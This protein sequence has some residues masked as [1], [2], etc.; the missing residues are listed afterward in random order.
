M[1]TEIALFSTIVMKS[2]FILL[3]FLV[4]KSSDQ[5]LATQ[6]TEQ[7]STLNPEDGD[8]CGEE[9]ETG[10][11]MANGELSYLEKKETRFIL[12]DKDIW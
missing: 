4:F 10:F 6:H 2:A 11:F 1:R 5:T 8:E 12:T 9:C 7:Q 3:L